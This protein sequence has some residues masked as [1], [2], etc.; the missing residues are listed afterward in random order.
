MRADKSTRGLGCATLLLL[1]VGW[2][3]L[4]WSGWVR[5]IFLSSPL[6][7]LQ[8]PLGMNMRELGEAALSSLSSF[9]IGMLISIGVGVPLGILIGSSGRLA[10]ALSPLVAILQAMPRVALAPLLILWLGIGANSVVALIVMN[11]IVLVL[12]TTATGVKNIDARWR[13][14]ALAFRASQLQLVN[15]VVLPASVPYVLAGI[16]LAIGRGL[17]SMV[18]GEFL[19]STGG[20]GYLIRAYASSFQTDRMFVGVALVTF[21][22]LLLNELCVRLEHKLRGW[23]SD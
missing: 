22:G 12:V 11:A 6:A 3:A 16:R 23:R 19:T 8:A 1:V 18:V 4:A 15:T 9:S 13:E 20:L 2:Q 5:P 10:A 7:I 14:T 21:A 17:L